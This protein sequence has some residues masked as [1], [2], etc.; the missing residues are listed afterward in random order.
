MTN[1]LHARRD[2]AAPDQAR[3]LPRLPSH[4]GRCGTAIFHE[5][6]RLT[7]GAGLCEAPPGRRV[8]HGAASPRFALCSGSDHTS[9]VETPVKLFTDTTDIKGNAD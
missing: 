5:S 9:Q 2:I 1:L 3:V 7:K 4:S 6:I 8:G